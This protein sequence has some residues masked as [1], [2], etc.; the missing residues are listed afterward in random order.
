MAKGEDEG[1]HAPD[2]H[3]D[4]FYFTKSAMFVYHQNGVGKG[5]LRLY[6]EARQLREYVY[7]CDVQEC[8]AA[9]QH[10]YSCGVDVGK[11]LFASLKKHQMFKPIDI[12]ARSKG[13]SI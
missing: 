9:E 6:A 3:D 1:K 13:P 4:Q 10:R 12:V 2:H 11:G 7:G 8:S 5:G